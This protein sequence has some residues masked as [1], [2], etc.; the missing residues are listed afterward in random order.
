MKNNDYTSEELI[1]FYKKINQ[2]KNKLEIEDIQDIFETKEEARVRIEQEKKDFYLLKDKIESFVNM[3]KVKPYD[4]YH[5]VFHL[6]EDYIQ[7]NDRK[8]HKNNMKSNPIFLTVDNVKEEPSKRKAGK[9]IAYADTLK[10]TVNEVKK[11]EF[12]ICSGLTYFGKS[13]TLKSA[14]K[15]H[16]FIIDLDYVTADTFANFMSGMQ[17]G[18]YPAPNFIVQSGHGLHIYYVMEEPI[19]LYPYTKQL[20]KEFKYLLTKRIWNRYTSLEEKPQ[21]QGINQAFRIPGSKTKLD[22]IKTQAYEF[23]TH[24]WT[25]EQLDEYTE[26]NSIL[27]E[28]VKKLVYKE[29]K[30][31]LAEAKEKYPEWYEHTVVNKKPT[32]KIEFSRAIYDS[33]KNRILK[34]A[35]FGHRY[36]C[37]MCLVIFGMKAKDVT[38][39]EIENDV[40]EL[41]P[42]LSALHREPFTIAD[43][44]AALEVY[45]KDDTVKWT[46]KNISRLTNIEMV[47][48]KRNWQKQKEHL[49]EARTIRDIR[50]K[51]KDTVWYNKNGAP[52]KQVIVEQWKLDNPNGTKYQCIKETGI[53]K[54]T[55]YKW[56]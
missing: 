13:N 3:K 6:D 28:M 44:K 33:F 47:A 36:H 16:A 38:Y 49:E 17:G 18:W 48:Q 40:Y 22:G 30:I 27:K 26:T 42:R 7:K 14:N 20:M 1:A 41:Q 4:L 21:I 11:H 5:T 46:R 9:Y 51:R 32:R 25:I 35:A 53:S 8:K 45:D 56:W 23:N 2:N 50:M 54:P 29:S 12:A 19:A 55:V 24:P 43:C 39:E 31:T 34:E 52:T 10:K 15:L 37:V